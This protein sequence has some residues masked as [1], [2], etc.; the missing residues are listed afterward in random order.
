MSSDRNRFGL[1]KHIPEDVKAEVRR[2]S[3]QG[4]VICRA[5]A[6][7]YHHIEPRFEAQEHNPK[8][9]CLLCLHHHGEVTRG[10]LT[11]QQV[12]SAYERVQQSA[13]VSP[14]V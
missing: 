13:K 2:R 7:D 12:L 6:Y 5:I 8:H 4:C 9:I 11:K 1:P 10:R 3:K 14:H